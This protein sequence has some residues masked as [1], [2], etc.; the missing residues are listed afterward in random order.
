M[1]REVLDP[2]HW[3]WDTFVKLLSRRLSSACSGA[4]VE[5]FAIMR[6][7]DDVDIVGTALWLGIECGIVCDCQIIEYERRPPDDPPR[8]HLFLDPDEPDRTTG[9]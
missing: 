4:L 7:W 6:E 5:A 1:P 2:N 3:R 9:D 8:W